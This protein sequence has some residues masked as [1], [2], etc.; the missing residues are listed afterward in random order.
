[1]TNAVSRIIELNAIYNPRHIYVDRGAGETQVEML[2]KHG[3]ENPLT[4]LQ[5]KVVGVAFRESIEVRDPYTKIPSKKEAK[6]FMVDNMRLLFENEQIIFPNSD[7]ELF[8]QYLAYAVI[9]TSIYG[10]PVF[11]SGGTA[12]HAHDAI[13]L[14][15]LAYT[16]N[17]STYLRI[18][19][20]VSPKA[21]SNEPFNPLF[22]TS[23]SSEIRVSENSIIEEKWGDVA[24][25][26][27]QVRRNLTY[28]VR[29][30]NK[31]FR[32]RMF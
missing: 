17:H 9:R 23:D 25:A 4:G 18:D 12:D 14:A 7:Y 32:R 26:P 22:S 19:Y 10:S 5:T 28:S 6:P 16:Q 20:D 21:T 13:M 29:K 2:H 31:P 24:N 1:M 3:K 8:K 11:D 15:A 27:V 30:G